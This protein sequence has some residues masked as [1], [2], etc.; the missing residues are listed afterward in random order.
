MTEKLEESNLHVVGKATHMIIAAPAPHSGSFDLAISPLGRRN[1]DEDSCH[2]NVVQLQGMPFHNFIFMLMSCRCCQA[3]QLSHQS[4]RTHQQQIYHGG[5][6]HETR[7][8]EQKLP[9]AF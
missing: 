4:I 5:K 8:A 3:T 7:I 2:L 1:Y 9:G 6:H